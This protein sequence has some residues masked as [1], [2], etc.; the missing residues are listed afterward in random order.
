EAITDFK[1]PDINDDVD[2]EESDIREQDNDNKITRSPFV[3]ISIDDSNEIEDKERAVHYHSLPDDIQCIYTFMA[4]PRERVRL[5]FTSF[6]LAEY[7]DV[8]SELEDPTEDL[9]SANL[10]A[11]YCGTVA[12]NV[13]IS[14]HQVLVLVLHSRIGRRRG[15]PF[16]LAGTFEFIPEAQFVPGIPFGSSDG[17]GCAFIIES[18]NRNQ[19]T[20]LSPTYPG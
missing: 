8:Y 7:V 13:R 20:I 18:S 5:Q 10:D 11:R 1:A 19:G 3:T 14:L 16:V 4:K 9:L 12:P 2:N 6:Q 15:D 17:K